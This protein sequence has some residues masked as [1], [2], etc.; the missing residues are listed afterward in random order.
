M[1]EQTSLPGPE[2]AEDEIDL[3][4][5]VAVLLDAKWLIGGATLLLTMAAL[6]YALLATPVY[7][8]DTLIQVEP[9]SGGISGL[10]ELSSLMGTETPAQG[11][12]EILKSRSVIGAAVDVLRLDLQ[13]KPVYFP[14]VGRGLA[15]LLAG[16]DEEETWDPAFPGLNRFAWGDESITLQHLT[17]PR[18]WIGEELLLISGVSGAYTLFSPDEEVI[19]IGR[20]GETARS[21]DGQVEIFVAALA[22]RPGTRFR[23]ARRH[24]LVVIDNLQQNLQ[25]AERGKSTGIIAASLEG[26][27]P[28]RLAATVQTVANLY[29]RQN[30]ERRSAEAEKTLEFINQQLPSLKANLDAAEARLNAYQSQQG[31]INLTLETQGVLA[32]V[33]D[34]EKQLSEL[35][36]Q[37]A[38]LAEKF[39]VSHPV[40]VTLQQQRQQ[41][42]TKLAALNTQIK[43]MPVE[44]QESVRLERDVKVANELYL[45][46]LNKAQELKV[47][48]AG[49]V[50]NVR[51]I[52][53]AVVPG[54]PVKPNKKLVLVLGFLLG[55]MGGVGAALVR[56]ALDRGVE[57]A[58]KIE[59]A[60]GIPVY[61]TITHSRKQ[62]DLV[63]AAR[64]KKSMPG[65]PSLLALADKEDLALESLRSLR[66]SLQFA[67]ME[68]ENNI[69]A[70]SGPSP[71]IGKS[72]VAAN[73]AVVL[74]D[75]N[76][77]ILLID[78]DM[79]KGHLH[80]YFGMTRV[81][82]LSGLI[83][84]EIPMEEAIHRTPHEK[85]D[86]M[87]CG[88]VPPNPSE[89]L[90]NERFRENLHELAGR[91][92][93]LIVDTPPALAVTDGL[94]VA[95]LAGTNFLVLK[96]GIHPMAEIQ[97][98]VKRY[99]QNKVRPQGIILN[100]IPLRTSRYGYGKYGYRYNYQY[101]YKSGK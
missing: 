101:A 91:Y 86:F 40:M 84:G 22:G 30:V 63:A 27:D 59:A 43:A 20:V 55:L 95:R 25:V 83:S 41:L 12:I 54:Q 72:F 36:L 45:L 50:G 71:G 47:L 93:L 17:L 33:A 29:L 57:D 66:T 61:A 98:A 99:L 73:L 70:I 1:I 18:E 2:S 80:E 100:D 60:V 15:R 74:A 37:H 76:K 3:G 7:Q 85:L 44:V 9:Q 67:L 35:Q 62:D 53:P 24:R 65:E 97:Q 79:R 64:K 34:A 81:S 51:I 48:K 14:V 5:M 31:S 75:G 49:T 11:E 38:A 88:I 32:G 94:I 52:D 87:P 56:K 78:A 46:L 42:E 77:R 69:V 13:A 39:T 8:T 19:L 10:E 28:E 92:D 89:L 16:G 96:Y 4:Q 68:A 82:G 26:T 90:M 23:V 6:A 21:A 58:D